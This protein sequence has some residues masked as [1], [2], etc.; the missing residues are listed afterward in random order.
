M[1]FGLFNPWIFLFPLAAA[2]GISKST[3]SSSESAKN[4]S[5]TTASTI[6]TKSSASCSNTALE[7]IKAKQSAYV[8]LPVDP[9]IFTWCCK[10]SSGISLLFFLK[11]SF[12][13]LCFLLKKISECGELVNFV[14]LVAHIQLFCFPRKIAAKNKIISYFS[15]VVDLSFYAYSKI[16]VFYKE[17]KNIFNT[18]LIAKDLSIVGDPGWSWCSPATFINCGF[19]GCT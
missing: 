5:G 3:S 16:C 1:V 8:T 12:K 7:C 19:Y 4:S 2:T 14:K 6:A 13:K 18:K 17:E 15:S 9:R 11:L 10:V